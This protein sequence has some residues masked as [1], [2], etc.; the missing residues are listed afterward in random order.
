MATEISHSVNKFAPPRLFFSSHGCIPSYLHHEDILN[1]D[2]W[3]KLS[4]CHVTL[5]EAI[6]F[7]GF[8]W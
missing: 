3:G 6:D 2:F 1:G 5:S 8:L 4:E 7:M